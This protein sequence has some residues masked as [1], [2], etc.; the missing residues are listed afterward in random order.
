MVSIMVR[1]PPAAK[2]LIAQSM[3]TN[4]QIRFYG[5]K[6]LIGES[7]FHENGEISLLLKNNSNVIEIDIVRD[8]DPNMVKKLPKEA[9]KQVAKQK[10][11]AT[12]NK[13]SAV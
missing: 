11:K 3:V 13:Q 7:T 2:N 5:T 12:K 9:S 6:W 1:L 10:E 4:K 8:N